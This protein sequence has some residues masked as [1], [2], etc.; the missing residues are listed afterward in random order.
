M[1]YLFLLP[2]PQMFVLEILTSLLLQ[3]V[4]LY[5]NYICPF[6][7]RTHHL[8]D[9]LKPTPLCQSLFFPPTFICCCIDT[10]YVLQWDADDVLDVYHMGQLYLKFVRKWPDSQARWNALSPPTFIQMSLQT[11]STDSHH[12]FCHDQECYLNHSACFPSS[13]D[14]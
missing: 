14:A 2:T 6:N 12:H 4:T 8:V 9:K 13:L 10:S 1:F 11:L 5:I 7:N 3:S